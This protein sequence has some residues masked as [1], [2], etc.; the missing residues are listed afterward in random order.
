[1][2]IGLSLGCYQMQKHSLSHSQRLYLN[3]VL[4]Q[5]QTLRHPEFPNAAKGLDGMLTADSILKCRNSCGVL[6]GGLCE[7]VW[8]RQ[9]KPEDLLKHKDVDV[10]VLNPEFKLQQN[11]EGGID[12]WLQ[13]QGR[14]KLA[15]DLGYSDQNENWNENTNQVVLGFLAYQHS[16]LPKTIK[17]GLY[18]PS[19]DWIVEMR[20]HE[21]IS[22]IDFSRVNVEVDDSFEQAFY[23][24][25]RK[26]VKT[27]LPKFV[28]DKFSR[29]VLDEKYERNYSKVTEVKLKGLSLGQIAGINRFNE[30]YEENISSQ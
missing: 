29:Q 26:R 12:W 1:M 6:I 27:T 21:A 3:Q 20:K 5:L 14:I 16:T 24:K 7:E 9:T 23:N 18:I 22:R 8:S 30:N 11:F 4:E 19:P 17:P 10:L 15:S 28:L 25:I 2:S 13:K